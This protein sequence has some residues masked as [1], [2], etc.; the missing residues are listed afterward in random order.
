MCR[1]HC[2]CGGFI[3]DLGFKAQ[4]SLNNYQVALGIELKSK[5]HKEHVVDRN[6]KLNDWYNTQTGT[7]SGSLSLK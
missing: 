6:H 3:A 1:G 5:T 2:G 7:K 4:H